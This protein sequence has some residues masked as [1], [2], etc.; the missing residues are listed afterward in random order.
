MHKYLSCHW[1]PLAAYITNDQGSDTEKELVMILDE[2]PS[3]GPVLVPL[4][5][6]FDAVNTKSVLDGEWRGL[7]RVTVA[8]T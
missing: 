7:V 2:N 3:Y 6:L 8:T 5:R 1:S 4:L